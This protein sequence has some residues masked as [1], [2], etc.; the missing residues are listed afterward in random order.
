MNDIIDSEKKINKNIEVEDSNCN[1]TINNNVSEDNS[2]DYSYDNVCNNGNSSFTYL[3]KDK[4]GLLFKNKRNKPDGSICF[5]NDYG[6]TEKQERFCHAYVRMALPR[7]ASKAYLEAFP[8]TTKGRA[9]SSASRLLND[10]P[11]IRA[12][13]HSLN[14]EFTEKYFISRENVLAGFWTIYQQCLEGTPVMNTNGQPVTTKVAVRTADGREVQEIRAVYRFDSKGAN[15]ALTSIARYLG[16]F[17]ADTTGNV[18]VSVS[19]EMAAARDFI[20]AEMAKLH[21]MDA[22]LPI[23]TAPSE[24]VEAT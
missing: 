19:V 1:S 9:A 21:K 12:R 4:K 2:I 5:V 23:G 7:N 18:N 22:K 13:I 3:N 24:T 14:A 6:L 8:G 11:R 17:N 15:A 10:N 20:T 16:L